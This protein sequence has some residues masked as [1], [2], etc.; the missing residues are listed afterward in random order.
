MSV[1]WGI[2]VSCTD[3]ILHK[4]NRDGRSPYPSFTDTRTQCNDII[5][6]GKSNEFKVISQDRLGLK[7]EPNDLL[8]FA[9]LYLRQKSKATLF[10][11]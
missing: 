8:N 9:N 1:L 6:R 10:Y 11:N 2:S 7:P 3:K 4:V 5:N